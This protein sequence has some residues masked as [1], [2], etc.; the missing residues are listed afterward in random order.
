LLSGLWD[1]QPLASILSN[2]STFPASFV[3]GGNG[4]LAIPLRWELQ[5]GIG[6][7]KNQQKE[8]AVWQI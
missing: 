3:G 6:G 2:S 8:G 5:G 4:P 1:F 7:G